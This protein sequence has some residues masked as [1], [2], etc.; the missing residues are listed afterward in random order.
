M[1]LCAPL[2]RDRYLFPQKLLALAPKSYSLAS[3]Q[4]LCSFKELSHSVESPHSLAGVQRP[5]SLASNLTIPVP[6][7]PTTPLTSIPVQLI[8]LCSHAS[9]APRHML[10]L[11]L[12]PQ[13]T[14]YI[15]ISF[16]QELKPCVTLIFACL[17][18]LTTLFSWFFFFLLLLLFFTLTYIS[19]GTCFYLEEVSLYFYYLYLSSTITSTERPLRYKS[20]CFLSFFIIYHVENSF[21]LH[22]LSY[23]LVY[24]L[25]YCYFPF[26]T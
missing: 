6:Q 13:E 16:S 20:I 12:I 2:L 14:F 18:T 7:L 3:F 8:A 11:R 4:K 22:A 24:F 10:Y 15:L 1:V 21:C 19:T 5:A 26:Q 23:E 9:F 25:V 17:T